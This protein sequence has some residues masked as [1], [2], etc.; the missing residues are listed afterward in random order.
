MVGVAVAVVVIAGAGAYAATQLT[1]H[2][3]H[4]RSASGTQLQASGASATGGPTTTSSP[5]NGEAEAGRVDELLS[6][7]NKARDEIVAAIAGVSSC[8][9]DPSQG[10]ATM[11]TAISIRQNIDKAATSLKLS[12]LPHGSQ[13]ATDL[14]TVVQDSAKSDRDYEAWMQSLTGS[15]CTG[16]SAPKGSY[17]Q[18][19]ASA[20][21]QATAAKSI[22][23]SLWNP[24][25]QQYGLPQWTQAQ[26]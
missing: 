9:L 1:A 17:Y 4:T 6:Q 8:S 22:L 26:I 21:V 3:R 23:L 12:E 24:I 11:A 19:A 5:G 18:A 7:S 16:G 14:A 10:A 15:S 13:I 2:G 25:A 20:D